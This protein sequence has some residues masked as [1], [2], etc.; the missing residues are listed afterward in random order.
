MSKNFG[1]MTFDGESRLVNKSEILEVSIEVSVK[2][3]LLLVW[4]RLKSGRI[5]RI[6]KYS[7]PT[8]LEQIEED[9]KKWLMTAEDHIAGH[10]DQ[11]CKWLEHEHL[12]LLKD[13]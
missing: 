8:P 4:A 3:D 5:G 1:W 9:T 13:R 2:Q 12:H 11:I 7:K 6:T 10:L